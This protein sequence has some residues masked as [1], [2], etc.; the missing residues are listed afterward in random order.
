[1][2]SRITGVKDC[3]ICER[4]ALAKEARNPHLIAEMEHTVFVVGDH[5]FFNGY[6]LVLLKE[7]VREPFEL[8]PKAQREHFA[9]VMRAAKAIF[10]TF[11]PTKLNY[12]CYGNAEPHVHWHIV[13]RYE[14]DLYP[15]G[16]PW[17]AWR[18]WRDATP[19]SAR[20]ISD[21]R[22]SEIAAEIRANLT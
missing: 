18:T 10:A 12:S 9:E 19:E 11:G 5:Q 3:L 22:A 7:H 4:V 2:R 13:P 16:D 20:D 6:A 15:N 17:R 1:V 21:S 8:S 14:D